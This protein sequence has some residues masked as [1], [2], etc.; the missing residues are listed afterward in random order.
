[1]EELTTPIGRSSNPQDDKKT[2]YEKSFL[3]AG[4]PMAGMAAAMH[5]G[6]DN[7]D[8][9]NDSVIDAKW[10]TVNESAPGVS[11]NSRV[12]QGVGFDVSDG[13]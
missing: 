9:V 6:N 7:H 10:K 5:D 2:A 12:Y 1:M 11:M 3:N 13:C 4:F 8:G